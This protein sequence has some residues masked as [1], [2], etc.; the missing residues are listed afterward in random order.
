VASLSEIYV[1]V[2][3]YCHILT[4]PSE[5]VYF[6]ILITVSNAVLETWLF[7]LFKLGQ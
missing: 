4:L 5:P 1:K 6:Y 2:L 7:L 3:E